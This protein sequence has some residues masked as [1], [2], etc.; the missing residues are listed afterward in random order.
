M[1]NQFIKKL[2]NRAQ[3]KLLKD[4]TY[5]GEIS[6]ISGVWANSKSLENCRKELQEVFEDWLLLKFQSNE[7]N[8]KRNQ[9]PQRTS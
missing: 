1:L 4:G 5:F 6:G 3:Y 9:L 2:L 7:K 8:N